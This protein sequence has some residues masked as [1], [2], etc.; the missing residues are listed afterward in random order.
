LTAPA[1]SSDRDAG[2]IGND[3]NDATTEYVYP[4]GSNCQE[5][6]GCNDRNMRAV[7]ERYGVQVVYRDGAI[8]I[9]G[10]RA[11]VKKAAKVI[12]EMD[13]LIQSGARLDEHT[14]AS[15]LDY[16]ET[17]GAE[18]RVGF[19]TVVLNGREQQIRPR[20]LGQCIYLSAMMENDVVFSIGPA[21]TGKTFLA[22]AVAV[23]ALKRN[24]VKKIILCRPAVEA[25]E[26][27]G[28]LPGDLK[29]KVEPYFRPLYDALY[30]TIGPEKMVKYQEKGIIEI[31]PLAYMRG[32][33]LSDAY[34]I[35]DEAQNTTSRQMKMLLTRLGVGS[36]V[37]VTG[38]VTQI[39]LP[40][41]EQS[42][43]TEIEGILGGIE[44][45]AF[46]RLTS[47]DVVRHRLVQHIIMAYDAHES[48]KSEL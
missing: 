23:S 29:E 10:E 4:P 22:V 25:G 2:R 35:L 40:K 11:Q 47:R 42:G 36:R 26:N 32:R 34:I 27:L 7:E 19:E 20:S 14:I 33:T 44:G 6:F 37:V 45:V 21:G 39:D 24:E 48:K 8:K 38:D 28:F 30:D 16:L 46:V 18:C 43:L 31:S 17:G 9:I 12:T 3:L 15:A 1:A 41:N 13:A 5:L